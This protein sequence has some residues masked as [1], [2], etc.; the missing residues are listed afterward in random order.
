VI[1]GVATLVL[2]GR[3]RYEPARY[4]AALAVA[5]TIAG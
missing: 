2:V 5:A 4:T 3:R 1:A